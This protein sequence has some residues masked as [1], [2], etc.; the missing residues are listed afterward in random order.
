MKK[1]FVLTPI[2]LAL[3]LLLFTSA[4]TTDKANQ[5]LQASKTALENLQDFSANFQ[6]AISHP[7]TRTIARSGSVK[8]KPRDK[9]II[10]FDN[11]AIYCD[12]RTIWVL[13]KGEEPVVTVRDFEPEEDWNLEVLFEIYSAKATPRYDGSETVHGVRCHKVFLDILDKSL[14]YEQAYVWI[15]MEN[16]L[17]EKVVMIDGK[18]ARTTFEFLQMTIN[19]GLENADFR[20]QTPSGA[21]EIDERY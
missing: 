6:Y 15:N 9:F 3:G 1:S 17:P 13:E 14:D 12:G 4:T 16:D 19:V 18:N 10:D 11:E 7:N 20:L 8:F 21:T 2:L 5:I